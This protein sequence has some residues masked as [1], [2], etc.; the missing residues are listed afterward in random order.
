MRPVFRCERAN[1]TGGPP[2]FLV[3]DGTFT[4]HREAGE[5]L[6]WLRDRDVSPHTQ[7]MY[8]GRIA[9][10]LTI[11]VLKEI[12]W[13]SLDWDQLRNYRDELG[14]ERL[15]SGSHRMPSGPSVN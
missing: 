2:A 14:R 7:R 6:Q 5:Y 3:V 13:R 9:R 11:C 8:A 12:D 10:F 4:Q 1:M 15:P